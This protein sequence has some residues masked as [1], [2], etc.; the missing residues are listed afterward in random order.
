MSVN[1]TSKPADQQSS[2]CTFTFRH[3]SAGQPDGA[4]DAH[5]TVVVASDKKVA[6]VFA[7]RSVNDTAVPEVLKALQEAIAKK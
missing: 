3:S 6:A 2:P 7:Y 5:L 1:S 4:Y